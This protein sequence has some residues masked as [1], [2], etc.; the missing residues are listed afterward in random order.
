MNYNLCLRYIWEMCKKYPAFIYLYLG[1]DTHNQLH[2]TM[3]DDSH[4][5]PAK[6]DFV[7]EDDSRRIRNASAD[8]TIGST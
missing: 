3:G 1:N 6:L 4:F 8:E 7:A 2:L 5:H